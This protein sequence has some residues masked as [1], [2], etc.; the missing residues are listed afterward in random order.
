MTSLI[1]AIQSHRFAAKPLEPRSRLKLHRLMTHAAEDIGIEV[2][3]SAEDEAG[4]VVI[5]AAFGAAAA[6]ERIERFLIVT[7]YFPGS[8][9]AL[10]GRLS[11]AYRDQQAGTLQRR[12]GR[13]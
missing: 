8:G 10:L 9:P 7:D 4:A 1:A 2:L 12:L 5:K 6:T 13:T 11:A 3:T